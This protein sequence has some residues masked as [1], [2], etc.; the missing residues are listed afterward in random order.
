MKLQIK[1]IPSSSKNCVVGWLEDTLKIK[2]KAP[3]DKGKANKAVI[4]LLEKT[5][6]LP[7]GSIKINRGQ[8]SCIKII[9]INEAGND[10]IKNKIAQILIK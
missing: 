8:T 3:P 4:S 2:V 5:L 1:V 6:A 10:D 7:R 9:H